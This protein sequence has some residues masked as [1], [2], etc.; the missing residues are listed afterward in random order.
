MNPQPE[1]GKAFDKQDWEGIA[2]TI[3]LS[4][5]HY[6]DAGRD[7]NFNVESIVDYLKRCFPDSPPPQPLGIDVEALAKA[8]ATKPLGGSEEKYGTV[9]HNEKYEAFKAGYASSLQSDRI[10]QL[11][12]GIKNIINWLNEKRP[13]VA[14]IGA[15]VNILQGLL[16]GVNFDYSPQSS[17]EEECQHPFAFV[18][19]RCMGEINHCLKCGKNL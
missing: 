10:T 5:D 4:I 12:S 3:I 16:D 15:P 9:F 1:E 7:D 8:Y 14:G 2:K 18:Q 6:R 19:T 11:E 17:T 13:H